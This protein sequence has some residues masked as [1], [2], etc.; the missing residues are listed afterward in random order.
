MNVFVYI[1][2]LPFDSISYERTPF[3]QK[4]VNEGYTYPL[5][6]IMGY[7][8]GIQSTILTGRLP[9]QTKQWMPYIYTSCSN[10]NSF[11][12][13]GRLARWMNVDVSGSRLLRT[14]RYGVTSKFILRKGAKVS[15][16]PWSM[17]DRFFI[18][19]YYYMNELPSL[20]ELENE[21]RAT[22]ESRLLYFGPCLQRKEATRQATRYIKNLDSTARNSLRKTSLILYVDSLDHRGHGHGVGS[23]VW[24]S[25]LAKIDSDLRDFY[26]AL[27]KAVG[28][29]TFS[30]F[31]DHGMCNV[32]RTI[33]IMKPLRLMGLGWKDITLFIDATIVNIWIENRIG[34]KFLEKSLERIGQDRFII[35]NKEEDANTLRKVG[36]P[37]DRSCTGDLIIQAKPG[38]V[39]YPN[40]Y[41]DR[42]SFKG[43]HGYF[44]DE[45][46][47]QSFLSTNVDAKRDLGVYPTHIKDIRGLLLSMAEIDKTKY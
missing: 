9:S 16:V 25:A 18:Y 38:Y 39:F 20:I 2:A 47:Q 33:D 34:K 17:A 11:R 4:L 42:K 13:L 6:N 32:K 40:F 19:P 14:I 21:L 23:F 44:P 45:S 5:Q 28:N 29:F 36:V 22:H 24:N 30:I 46:C 15:S 31:S 3:I 12:V 8:F 43:A 26:N 10:I 35:L 27:E 37:L 41:S 1:D 7:S